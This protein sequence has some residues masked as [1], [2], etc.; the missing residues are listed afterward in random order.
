MKQLIRSVLIVL[1]LV[2][3]ATAHVTHLGNFTEDLIG[4]LE[5]VHQQLARKQW[6]SAEQ[7]MD[8]I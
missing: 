2:G 4:Q 3:L 8:K 7:A 6:L 1:L 5:S